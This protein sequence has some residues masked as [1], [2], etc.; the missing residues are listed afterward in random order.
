MTVCGALEAVGVGMIVPFLPSLANDMNMGATGIGCVISAAST[1]KVLANMP[2]GWYADNVGRK[3]L[4][5]WSHLL[6]AGGISMTAL[7]PNIASLL[8]SRVVVGVGSSAGAVGT[9]AYTVDITSHLPQHRGLILGVIGSTASFAYVLGP[10]AGGIVAAYLGDRGPFFFF[11]A[12]TLLS[13]GALFTVKETLQKKVANTSTLSATEEMRK[14]GAVYRMLLKDRGQQGLLFAN[15]AASMGWA[16]YLTLLPL[17]AIAVWGAT[18]VQLGMVFSLASAVGMLGITAGGRLSDK[19]GRLPVF[20]GGSV[21]YCVGCALLY[22]AS[23]YTEFMIALVVWEIGEAVLT[24][25]VGVLAAD[26]APEDKRGQ[27]LSL[28][29]QAGDITMLVA[30][31]MLGLVADCWVGAGGGLLA[32]AGMFAGLLLSSY[33]R[34]KRV[35]KR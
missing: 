20:A 14:A 34:L 15:I 8:A 24:G 23:N 7:S 5:I 25:L 27:S 30:P 13:T 33:S 21:M 9:S 16:A 4:L 6:M 18:P 35:V 32:C 19:I 10:A 2:A 31:L 3:P 22:Y 1:G 11:S 12:V 29:R 28:Q 26:I 17:H